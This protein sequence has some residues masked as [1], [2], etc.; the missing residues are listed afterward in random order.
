VN[1]IT[2][3]TL[4]KKVNIILTGALASVLVFFVLYAAFARTLFITVFEDLKDHNNFLLWFVLIIEGIATIAAILVSFLVVDDIPKKYSLAAGLVAF[5]TN[6]T[7]LI[8][9]SYIGLFITRPDLFQGL[10]G[11]DVILV[12]PTVILYFSIIILGHPIY[13]VL[14][15][16][17]TYFP[18]FVMYLELF[19][20]E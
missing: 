15:S 16:M 6:T 2:D 11:F 20:T 19:Y 17:L 14:L 5:L 1:K 3:I 18:L 4:T 13:F 9:I 7:L 8:V 12:F 10:Q